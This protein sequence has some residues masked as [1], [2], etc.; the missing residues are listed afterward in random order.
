M[1]EVHQMLKLKFVL[2]PCLF[3]TKNSIEREID[4]NWFLNNSSYLLILAL[5]KP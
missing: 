2:V 4:F 1:A 5:I 3:L